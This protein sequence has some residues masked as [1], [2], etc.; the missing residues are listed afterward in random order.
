M[1]YTTR[2]Y[3]APAVV[4]AIMEVLDADLKKR[5]VLTRHC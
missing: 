3:R 4:L 5:R 2:K 1:S